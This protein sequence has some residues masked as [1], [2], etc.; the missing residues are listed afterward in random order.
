MQ[1]SE[2]NLL[3]EAKK[4]TTQVVMRSRVETMLEYRRGEWGL[5]D[6]DEVVKIFNEADLQL[7]PKKPMTMGTLRKCN[8]FSEHFVFSRSS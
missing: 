6:I 5:Q 8:S 2:E 3:E 4:T 1:E 7:Q